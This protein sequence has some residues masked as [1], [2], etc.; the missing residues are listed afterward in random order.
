MKRRYRAVVESFM[1]NLRPTKREHN[2]WYWADQVSSGAVNSKLY[3]LIDKDL[4][5]ERTPGIRYCVERSRFTSREDRF[6]G[7]KY[8]TTWAIGIL[9]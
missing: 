1:L 7:L 9:N 6:L 2:E 3:N 5:W 4:D 8:F